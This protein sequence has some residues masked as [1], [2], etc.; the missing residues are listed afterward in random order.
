MPPV[1][2]VETGL[3]Q[4]TASTWGTFNVSTHNGSSSKRHC[5]GRAQKRLFLAT[6][7]AIWISLNMRRP[8]FRSLPKETTPYLANLQMSISCQGRRAIKTVMTGILPNVDAH[9]PFTTMMEAAAPEREARKPRKPAQGQSVPVAGVWL[10]WRA[11]L[12][13]STSSK[14]VWRKAW[15]NAKCE[16]G[17]RR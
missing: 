15:V 7:G 5:L 4:P 8:S 1:K 16:P 2:V 6:P 11:F 17:S 14:I 3:G 13:A 12:R 9:P 10:L